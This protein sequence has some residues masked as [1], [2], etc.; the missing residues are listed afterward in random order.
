MPSI[1]ETHE[2]E[3]EHVE[4]YDLSIE[5]RPLARQTRPGFWR[6]LVH[7]ITTYLTPTR[8]ERHTGSCHVSR[9]FE[10]PMD[11]LVREHP[12]L[13]TYALAMI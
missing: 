9:P 10:T 3:I 8:H 6:T 13:A 11:R 12:S 1:I 2:L 5:E 7:G 4:T